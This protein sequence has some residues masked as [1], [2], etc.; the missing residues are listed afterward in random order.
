MER[1]LQ[2]SEPDTRTT[3]QSKPPSDAGQD[4]WPARDS[5]SRKPL[6]STIRPK[7]QS[8]ADS[9]SWNS[10]SIN[11]TAP[12]AER[13]LWIGYDR[14]TTITDA[15]WARQSAAIEVQVVRTIEQALSACDKAVPLG[16]VVEFELGEAENGVLALE[17][18]RARGVRVPAVIISP[19]PELAIATLE[20]SRLRETIPV[21]G[22]SERY[23]RLRDWL[24]QL[25]MC[26][27]ML[28]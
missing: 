17:S 13:L 10:P 11:P 16:V 7:K 9:G 25:R 24:E 5:V 6:M 27:A 4:P 20:G 2:T 1:S 21:F 12:S 22:R 26:L 28:A 8:L 18:L 23:D 19:T 15:R 14:A 3:A